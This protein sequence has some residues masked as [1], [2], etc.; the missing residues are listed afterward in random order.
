[1]ARRYNS[2]R[3]SLLDWIEHV[4]DDPHPALVHSVSYGSD[5]AQQTSVAY[6]QSANLQ[7]M[8]A[9]PIAVIRP[10][11]RGPVRRRRSSWSNV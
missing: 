9:R 7:F 2:V 3:Y 10:R 6:M 11:D 1:M 8:K 5:E 4:N